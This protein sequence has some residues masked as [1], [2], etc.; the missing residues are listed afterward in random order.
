MRPVRV[1][2]MVESQRLGPRP[3]DPGAERGDVMGLVGGCMIPRLI[4]PEFFR[5]VGNAVP[6]SWALDGYYALLIRTGTGFA[7]VAPQLGALVGFA[8]V[9]CIIGIARFRFE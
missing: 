7:D 9:F 8:A 2:R 1:G 3:G 6:Q 4:M 5:T